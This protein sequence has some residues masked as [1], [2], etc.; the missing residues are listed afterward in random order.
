MNLEDFK[1]WKVDEL[2]KYVRAR[3]QTI[4]CK[5]KEE[6]VALAY[7]VTKQNLP[8]VPTK[9]D[10][11]EQTHLDYQALLNVDIGDLTI[12][13]EDPWNI[14]DGWQPESSGMSTWPPC[15]YANIAEYLID[16]DQRA[17]LSRLNNDYKE[18]KWCMLLF[19]ES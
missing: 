12:T 10:L 16:S 2:K 4:N 5:R 13:L 19:P 11:K 9:E 18:G 3:G 7:A 1:R 15:T 6:L 8:V 17:L 14:R